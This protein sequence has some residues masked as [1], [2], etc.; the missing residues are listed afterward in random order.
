M[1][2]KRPLRLKDLWVLLGEGKQ[3]CFVHSGWWRSKSPANSRPL[4]ISRILGFLCGSVF[5]G[6]SAYY[7][8]VKEYKLSNEMLTEDIYV[9]HC[10]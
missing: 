4:F 10:I 9:R 7:Y 6:G 8:V 2:Q 1:L 5:A 3:T